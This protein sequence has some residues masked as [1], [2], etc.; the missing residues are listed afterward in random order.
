[1]VKQGSNKRT[2]GG[3][4]RPEGNEGG[5]GP[6]VPAGALQDENGDFIRDENNDF[7]QAE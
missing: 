7:I 2:R 1:M 5:Q 3:R 6:S 4:P